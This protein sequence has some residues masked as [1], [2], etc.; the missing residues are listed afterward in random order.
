M[1]VAILAPYY[2][3]TLKGDDAFGLERRADRLIRPPLPTSGSTQERMATVY[4]ALAADVADVAAQGDRPVA[5]TGDCCATIGVLAGLQRAGIAPTLIWFDAHGDFN[6][7]ETS[8]SGFLG[9]MPLAMI[10]GR[11]EQTFLEATGATPLP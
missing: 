9:G 5:Y 4:Q 8:P 11:G 7:W 2:L 6:T 10:V 3:D 1:D